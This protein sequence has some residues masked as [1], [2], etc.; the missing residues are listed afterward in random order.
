MR[1][2]YMFY[3]IMNFNNIIEQLHNNSLHELDISLSNRKI[4]DKEAFEIIKMIPP[5]NCIHILNLS[6]R[7]T[8]TDEFIEIIKRMR[9]CKSLR[10]LRLDCN[11][12]Y[13]DGAGVIAEF[14]QSNTCLQ[15]LY[16]ET[17]K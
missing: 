16:L 12:T 11:D 7:I 8:N 3:Y 10:L 2:C 14:L 6:H 4:S 9:L 13:D 15:E 17:T 5:N 1:Y